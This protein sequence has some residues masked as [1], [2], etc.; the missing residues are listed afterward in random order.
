M[1]SWA[2]CRAGGW[3]LGAALR[4]LNTSSPLRHP[5]WE[6]PRCSMNSFLGAG[7]PPTHFLSVFRR[8]IHVSGPSPQPHSSHHHFVQGGDGGQGLGGVVG[9]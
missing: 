8:L 2:A 1:S 3:G 9:F 6:A 5:Q 4:P 7:H